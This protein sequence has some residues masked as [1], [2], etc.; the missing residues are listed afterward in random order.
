MFNIFEDNTEKSKE[1][2]SCKYSKIQEA[3]EE[4]SRASVEACDAIRK[5]N[6]TIP[7]SLLKRQQ[8]LNTQE[9]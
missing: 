8:R 6:G 4:Q 5:S 7:S 2:S 1:S 9:T 3:L